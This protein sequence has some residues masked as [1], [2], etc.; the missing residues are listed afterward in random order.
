MSEKANPRGPDG[1]YRPLSD[2]EMPW[3]EFQQ[4]NRFGL[5]FRALGDY[6]G[7]QH[8]GVCL[9]E[10][11]PGFETL[12]GTDD[13]PHAA[14]RSAERRFWGVQFHPEVSHTA[15][16]SEILDN[17]LKKCAGLAGDWTVA[18]FIQESVTAIREQV[19]EARVVL[20]L[21]GGVDSAVAALLIDRAIGDRLDCIFVDNGVLRRDEGRRVVETFAVRKRS[22]DS[23]GLSEAP[24]IRTVTGRL[25]WVSPSTSA[26]AGPIVKEPER[27]GTRM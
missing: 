12:A 17:F 11:A 20:G 2:S 3:Q 25:A 4:G 1:I 16:G 27:L 14:V 5:R 10:L 6:G 24:R 19:G 15:R 23:V 9:E 8:I 22:R 26:V 7:R 18:S 21:S 13:A